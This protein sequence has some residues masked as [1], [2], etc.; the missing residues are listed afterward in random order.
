MELW[1]LRKELLQ[2]QLKGGYMPAPDDPKIKDAK[3]NKKEQEIFDKFYDTGCVFVDDLKDLEK[4]APKLEK[5][6]GE[7]KEN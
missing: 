7:F 2:V 5:I 6:Y 3:F 1:S 4:I